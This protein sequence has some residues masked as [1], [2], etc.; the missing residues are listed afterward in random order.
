MT[1]CHASWQQ[2]QV[3]S[4]QGLLTRRPRRLAGDQSVQLA[5]IKARIQGSLRPDTPQSDP[6]AACV[7]VTESAPVCNEDHF[8]P[9]LD[10]ASY[11]AFLLV[12]CFAVRAL[13]LVLQVLCCSIMHGLPC[14]LRERASEV[15][16][17][18]MCQVAPDVASRLHSGRQVRL[19]QPHF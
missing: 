17:L 7:Q 11:A 9:E 19:P 18:C 2:G 15:L 6:C 1:A 4:H 14:M 16:G 13:C 8:V 3:C 5:N 12:A 10:A